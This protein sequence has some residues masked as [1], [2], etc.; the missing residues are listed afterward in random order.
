MKNLKWLW[1][2]LGI[3]LAFAVLAGVGFAGFQLGVAQSVNISDNM[4]MMFA[5]G[6][7]FDG[8]GMHG[9]FR[10]DDFGGRGGFGFL[11]PLFFLLRVAFWGGLIWLGYTLFKRSGWRLVN[12][13]TQAAPA[14]S[15]EKKK[16]TE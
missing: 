9:G 2:T 5:H 4:P 15:D 13:N 12:T 7:G 3:V 8:M 10:G 1:W 6:R 11:S 14:A 16:D